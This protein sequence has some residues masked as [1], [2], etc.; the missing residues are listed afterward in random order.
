MDLS[1][2][3]G[4][5]SMEEIL[6]SIR[7]IIAEEPADAIFLAPKLEPVE[8]ARR[9][10]A[11]D[12]ADFKLPSMFRPTSPAVSENASLAPVRLTDALR[13]ANAAAE[14]EA[15]VNAVSNGASHAN[16]SSN[17]SHANGHSVNGSNGHN[18]DSS[19]AY[20]ALSSL[21]TQPRSEPAPI[22]TVKPEP[23][24]P[25]PPAVA[26][27]ISQDA[28]RDENAAVARKMAS[29][30][31]CRFT[32]MASSQAAAPIPAVVP[33]APEPV[34]AAPIAA[35]AVPLPPVATAPIFGQAPN[36]APVHHHD[37][38]Q[39]NGVDDHTAELLRPMLRQ[40][41]T[42]NMP[43]MVEKALFMEVSNTTNLSKKD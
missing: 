24:A 8:P 22:V 16:G 3:T 28:P 17:G 37:A 33:P 42:E 39:A 4:Q 29:F 13:L 41:L 14:I 27:T 26:Q 12:G 11:D 38:S 19:A 15:K 36:A 23:I 9:V 5:P 30:A 1:E 10:E 18:G 6:A 32:S 35:P 43:R 31:D 34:T 7:R 20:A 25:S 40:W 2:K 21:R